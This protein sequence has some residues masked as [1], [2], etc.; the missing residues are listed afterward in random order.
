[1]AKID[2]KQRVRIQKE[3]FSIEEEIEKIKS[4]ST[5]I[6]GIVSFVGA[7]RDFSKGREVCQI[8]FEHYPIM[9]ERALEKVR[10]EALTRF[11]VIDVTIIHRI[12]M[13]EIGENIVLVIAAAQ[14][15]KEAFN[16]CEWCIDRLKKTVP[17][18][19]SETTPEGKIWVEAHP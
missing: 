7:A 10:E 13:I 4:V 8:E 16:A 17:I 2:I 5:R 18:W 6:G 12:G 14:H 19:K 11:P 3:P 9:A 1:M 15:R